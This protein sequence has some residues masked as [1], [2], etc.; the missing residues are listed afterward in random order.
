MLIQIVYLEVK[1]EKMDTFIAEAAANARA[2][3]S[4]PG[5]VRFDFLQQTDAPTKF[6]LYE[7]YRSAEALEAHRHTGHFKRWVEKGVPT[8][9]GER[10]RVMYRNIEPDDQNW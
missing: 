8:L 9:A 3:L 2:S 1:P 4:E 5:V 7:V 6:M 10:V